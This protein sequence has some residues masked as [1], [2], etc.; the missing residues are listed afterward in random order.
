MAR[1]IPAKVI[2]FLA[3]EAISIETCRSLGTVPPAPTFAV[4]QTV[5]TK[6]LSG[7]ARY[8]MTI[9]TRSRTAICGRATTC[10]VALAI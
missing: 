2:A 7:S 8:T 1:T 10:P 6:D 5:L 9:A 4:A 3:R